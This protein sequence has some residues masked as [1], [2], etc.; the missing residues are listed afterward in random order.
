M[1]P[2]LDIP[3]V[4]EDGCWLALAPDL[5][6]YAMS[7]YLRDIGAAVAE[8]YA[9]LVDH[10]ML[11]PD[12]AVLSPAAQAVALALAACTTVLEEPAMEG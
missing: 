6:L 2:P 7:E 9:W 11:A 10:Y 8:Q 5:G 3:L 12:W 1:H 4:G